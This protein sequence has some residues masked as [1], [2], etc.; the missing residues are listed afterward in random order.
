MSTGHSARFTQEVASQGKWYDCFAF[1]YGAEDSTRL[2]VLFRDVTQAR[3]VDQELA[4]VSRRKDEFLAMLAHELRN[5]LAP[6][7]A[8]ASLLEMVSGDAERVKKTGAV[9]ARQ[10]RHM[11]GLVDDLLDV[12]R[13]TRGEVNLNLSEVDLHQVLL[14]S[15]EQVR[16]LLKA[17][18]HEFTLDAPPLAALVDGD[19]KRL[20]QTFSN[21][22][23]N[24]AKYTPE[25][26]SITVSMRVEQETVEV[27]VSDTGPGMSPEL[28]KQCF[29]LF[30]QGERTSER[31]GGGLGIGLSL[32]R[33]IVGLHGGTVRAE[34][35][36]IGKG[37]RFSV[38]LPR[39]AG[40]RDAK[41]L[42]SLAAEQ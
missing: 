42:L 37:S 9:I 41:T 18:G 10:V 23:T 17:R 13:V 20:V 25:G 3:L 36:G 5:P 14:E 19:P 11:T 8:G 34:S 40:G 6:I 35:P 33:S 38:S 31:A 21:L 1:R 15:I 24:A 22:L 12:S 26:G 16:P 29:D 7:A 32:V 27:S 39:A 28:L 2:G 30:V 4:S